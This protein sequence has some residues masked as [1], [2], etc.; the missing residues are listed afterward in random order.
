VGG[1]KWWQWR[2]PSEEL[3]GEW[4]EMRNHYGDCNGLGSHPMWAWGPLAREC[5]E[6]FDRVLGC[7]EWWQWRGPSEELKGEWIEM[8]NHYNQ[9]EGAGGHCNRVMATWERELRRQSILRCKYTSLQFARMALQ[10]VPMCV[11]GHKSGGR[12]MVAM[13]RAVRRAEGGVD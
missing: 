9:T 7:I 3:K 2:G 10:H 6:V 1:E 12:E 4:I 8:R 13:A 5:L 11:E